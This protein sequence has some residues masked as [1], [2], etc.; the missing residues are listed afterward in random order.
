MKLKNVHLERKDIHIRNYQQSLSRVKGTESRE[1]R[2]LPFP[3]KQ[4]YNPNWNADKRV[5]AFSNMTL[6]K[7]A[8]QRCE[9]DTDYP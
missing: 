1:F 5:N 8:V 7:S 3:V 2:P 6:I 4:N 9:Y